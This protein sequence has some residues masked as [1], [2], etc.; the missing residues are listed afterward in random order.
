[1]AF[2]AANKSTAAEPQA[3][4]KIAFTCETSHLFLEEFS[5]SQQP[6]GFSFFQGACFSAVQKPLSVLIQGHLW[7]NICS[8]MY[9][10]E[11]L[12]KENMS[13][14]LLVA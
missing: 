5:H 4:N 7:K 11:S 2:L 12:V 6:S 9:T 8:P 14:N 13:E 1:L 3:A 10:V